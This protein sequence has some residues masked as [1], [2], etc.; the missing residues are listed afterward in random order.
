M[1]WRVVV[2][3]VMVL[4]LGS[5]VALAQSARLDVALSA[6]PPS[7]TVGQSTKITLRVVPLTGA[8]NIAL[9]RSYPLVATLAGGRSLQADAMVVDGPT[10]SA[11]FTFDAAGQWVVSSPS[12]QNAPGNSLT[13]TVLPGAAG[14]T[15]STPALPPTRIPTQLPRTGESS[16]SLVLGLVALGMGALAAGVALRRGAVRS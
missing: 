1:G 6:E 8:L 4:A 13:I 12:F 7:P 10:Y 11:S 15:G 2:G 3:L 5:S 9:L 16:G 14:G